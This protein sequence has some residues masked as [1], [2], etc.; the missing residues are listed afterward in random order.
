[1]DSLSRNSAPCIPTT[2]GPKR[3]EPA[4]LSCRTSFFRLLAFLADVWLARCGLDRYAVFGD[5]VDLS[6]PGDWCAAWRFAVRRLCRRVCQP[7]VVN[8]HAHRL[9]RSLSTPRSS[10][11]GTRRTGPPSRGRRAAIPARDR[12]GESRRRWE[13]RPV[14]DLLVPGRTTLSRSTSSNRELQGNPHH[15]HC[16]PQL[17][18]TD[19]GI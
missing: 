17:D 10:Q 11:R 16:S 12:F 2:T 9:V 3:N 5:L 15:V 4:Y 7:A 13:R 8:P 14:K 18:H 19:G 6:G 1:M